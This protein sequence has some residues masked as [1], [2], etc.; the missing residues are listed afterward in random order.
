MTTTE[1]SKEFDVLINSHPVAARTAADFDE[2]EKSVFLT[3]A[4]E[5]IVRSLYNGN[6]L[7][8]EYNEG[9]RRALDALIVTTSPEEITDG[10]CNGVS[11]SSRFFQLPDNLWYIT[12][13]AVDLLDDNTCFTGTTLVVP[14]RQD[15]WH[16]I[17][18]NPFRKPNERRVVRLDNG[19]LIAELISAYSFD[20]YTIRYLKRP[21]PIILV[22]LDAPLAIN[23]VSTIT[24]CELN[25]VLH[26][27]ILEGAVQLASTRLQTKDKNS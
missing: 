7:S 3:E 2:Y 27:S 20:N 26:R 16:R 8:F 21:S 15:D 22:N 24:E 6:S 1:F 13:E 12:Y 11:S 4:Q 9:D 19:S 23:G 25:T 10:S 5:Q 14:I 18:K 17:R